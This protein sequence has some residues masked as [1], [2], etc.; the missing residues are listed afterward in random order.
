MSKNKPI[1]EAFLAIQILISLG[2]IYL[3]Y[4]FIETGFIKW[5]IIIMV[6]GGTFYSVLDSINELKKYHLEDYLKTGKAPTLKDGIRNWLKAIF[7]LI[8]FLISLYFYSKIK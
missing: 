7:F 3:I 8:L 4:N 5:P 6:A 1:S 2:I